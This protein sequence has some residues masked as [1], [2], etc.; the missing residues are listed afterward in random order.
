MK[1]WV[2]I[3]RVAAGILVLVAFGVPSKAEA[4]VGRTVGAYAVSQSGAAIYAIP[5][6]APH[7]PNGLEPS[8]TLTYSSQTGDGP[9]GVGWSL[10]GLSS[11]Y[12]C[13]RT[14]AQDSAPAAIS[15]S[16]SDGYC[17][18]GRRLRLTAGSYGVAGSTYQTEVANF[19]NVTANGSAGNGPAYFEVQGKDGRIYEYGNGGGSQVLASGTTTAWQWW[20]D[21]VTDRAGNT[22][23][24]SYNNST[25]TASPA[26][27]SWTP[28]SHGGSTYNYTMQFAYGTNVPQSSTYGYVGGTSFS[29]SSLL[30]SITVNYAGAVVKQYALTYQ[31]SPTTGRD[32]LAKV[33]E[34]ADTAHTNCLSPTSITYQSGSA[35]VS[36][37]ASSLNL[38]G[39]SQWYMAGYDVNGD[40]Y[41]DLIYQIGTSWYVAF[42]SAS[43]YGAPVSTGITTAAYSASKGELLVGDLLG[44]GDAGLLANNGGTWYYWTWNGSSFTAV[45]TRVPYDTT[46]TAFAL[47]DTNGDGLPDLVTLNLTVA[48]TSAVVYIRLN[49]SSGGVVGFGASNTAYTNTDNLQD[50]TSNGGLRGADIQHAVPIQRVDFN[51]D[52]R[53]DLVLHLTWFDAVDK[54]HY[55]QGYYLIANGTT[56]SASFAGDAVGAYFLNWNDDRCTDYI[57]GTSLYLSACNGTAGSTVNLPVTPIAT[58][59]WNGDGREDFLY[60]SGGLLYVEPSTGQGLGSGIATGFAYNSSATYMGADITGDGLDDLLTWVFGSGTITYNL[61]KGTGQPPDL[62]SSITDGYGNSAKPTYVSMIQSSGYS[63]ATDAHFP[64]QG[65]IGPIYLVNQTTFSDPSSPP[66]GTYQKSYNYYRAWMN[67][68]GRGFEGF[69]ETRTY[70]S[71][72]GVYDYFFYQPAFPYTG[73]ETQ[74]FYNF[75][76][77]TTRNVENTLAVKELDSATN[78]ERYFPYFSNTTTKRKELGGV[79]N[80]DQIDTVSTN[81]SFDNYGNATEIVTTVTDNDPG[82]PYVGDSWTATVTNTTDVDVS[83]WCLGLLT[84]SQ[85]SYTA[86]NGSAVTRTQDYTPDLTNCR[87]TQVVT[88][89]SSTSYKVTEGLGFDSFGNIDSDTITGVG[90]TARQTTSNWGATGQFPMSVTDA[91]SAKIQLNYD[92]RYGT[93]SSQTDPNGLPTTWQYGDGFGRVTQETRPDNTYTTWSYSLYSGS[94]PKPRLHIIEAPHDSAGNVISETAKFLDMAD[95][96]YTEYNT[97]LD[98]SLATVV[99]RTYDSLGRVTSDQVPFEGSPVGAVTY[100]YDGLNRITK[101]Q[102]PINQSDS[103]LQTTSYAYEGRTTSITDPQGHART[104]IHDVNGWLRQSQDALGYSVVLDYDAAGAKTSVT[105]SL[106]HILWTG[107]YAYGLA[108][109]LT[110]ETDIDRG[111]WGYTVDALGERTAWTDPKAQSFSET[112]DALSRPLTRT[113]PDLFTQWTWGSSATSYNVGKLQSVCSGAGTSCT[114]SSNSDT[115]TYDSNGRLSQEITDYPAWGTFTT[116]WQYDA[117]TGFL[118]TLTYPR[119]IGGQFELKYGYQNGILQSITDVLDSPN[120]TI[121]TANTENAAGQLTQET[122]GNGLVTSRAYDAVTGWLASIQSGPGGGA[123]S[124]NQSFLYD[125]VGNVT[126]RQDNNLGLTENFYYD[127]DYRLSHSTLNGTQNLSLTYDPMGNITS[128]SDLA[129]GATWTYDPTHVHEA[130]QAGSAAYQYAY[131]AN[132]NVKTRQ[133]VTIG[134]SSYNYPTV[135]YADANGET[136]TLGYDDRRRA[137]RVQTKGSLGL[138]TIYHVADGLFDV[139]A[140]S[141][142]NEY[143]HYIYAGSEPV[144]IASRKSSGVNATYYL[145]TDQQGGIAAITNSTGGIVV[146]ESFA[147]YGGRRNA[148]TWSGAPSSTD[149]ATMAGIT[150]HGYTFQTA[151]GSLMG[152]NY[153]VGRVQDAVTGRWLSA[154][155]NIPDPED[156]QSYNRYSYVRNNPLTY[157]DPSGFFDT[158]SCPSCGTVLVTGTGDGPDD[159]PAAAGGDGGDVEPT[160]SAADAN[161]VRNADRIAAHAAAH[162]AKGVGNP[163]GPAN[164]TN[165]APS[166]PAQPPTVPNL[167]QIG[168]NAS[169]LLP[170]LPT[171][172]INFDLTPIGDGSTGEGRQRGRQSNPKQCRQGTR[173]GNALIRYGRDTAT[174]GGATAAVGGGIIAGGAVATATVA[175]APEGIAAMGTGA[176]VAD[177]GGTVTYIGLGMQAIGGALNA[178]RGNLGSLVSAGIHTAAAG[179]DALVGHFFPKLPD[180]L[181]PYNPVD[182]AADRASDRLGGGETCP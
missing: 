133:G 178:S 161:D 24:I 141:A 131:D 5:I 88:E 182:V 27:I 120:V 79:E 124:Q 28:S 166:Q 115:Y 169:R 180:V 48:N 147:A 96:L 97:Q 128:R 158:V 44:T 17:M 37:T 111:T 7:G 164:P 139:V 129:S 74:E 40:G 106:G 156:P 155:P 135:F 174:V 168:I 23:K 69:E 14:Y 95:R 25:G 41:K 78:N 127:N 1:S 43:G 70:D 47:A 66:G 126:Q 21:K 123:S 57:A 153:M 8:L 165:P 65:Y 6:W 34:C 162:A 63:K 76:T 11:V 98:G 140:T 148:T 33:Q 30:S 119:S 19:S 9:I 175:F 56:F 54:I 20:L 103:T 73:M 90:M 125:E 45:S 26:T 105:D 71:R 102:R 94:D 49:A 163:T 67:L 116:T 89:P 118:D 61:H 52:G 55:S 110:G 154:D 15:L 75:P 108:P 82:S 171:F 87:Y 134:W 145:L 58:I 91:T 144:A 29:N 122:L 121:W 146:G 77:V 136:V 38:G 32:E 13:N 10:T 114:A 31:Q 83:T 36:A 117:T 132:G 60:Q 151:L 99:L 142:G 173:L 12:R 113:E 100:S 86:S 80:G 179:V 138:E 81:Y 53:D 170:S 93:I 16:T 167:Q 50:A 39:T 149:L 101:I 112:Y 92:F 59:D 62:L 172:S 150:R 143:R 4:A 160:Y 176:V 68:Q 18:D 109:Y 85:T 137:Y 104:L 2:S 157:I 42:G 64:D 177:A 72:T 181:G 22:M 107:S 46:A 35:G 3:G 152:L 130:T 84:E 159:S 51:G